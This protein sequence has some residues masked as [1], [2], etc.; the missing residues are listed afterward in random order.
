[1]GGEIWRVINIKNIIRWLCT[2][3][4][5]YSCCL[6]VMQVVRWLRVCPFHVFRS[7][8]LYAVIPYDVRWFC[9][10]SFRMSFDD[11]VC[12]HSVWRSMILYAV[13]PYDVRWFCAFKQTSLRILE[14]FW[15][16]PQVIMNGELAF[17]HAKM[18]GV[19]FGPEQA[20]INYQVSGISELLVMRFWNN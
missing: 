12:C 9:M 19:S 4:D 1:M 17:S 15:R 8:I 14:F 6:M 20:N 5:D 3:L 18:P 13:I 10:L 7:M 2:S 11:S 16:I